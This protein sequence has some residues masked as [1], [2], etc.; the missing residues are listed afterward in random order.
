VGG[1][2]HDLAKDFDCVNQYI[3]ESKLN[4]YGIIGKAHKWIK[5]YLGLGIKSVHE[6]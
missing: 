2:F 4:F 6:N 3:V 5:T 1:I